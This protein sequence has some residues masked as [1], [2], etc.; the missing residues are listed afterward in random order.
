M[1]KTYKKFTVEQDLA[2]ACMIAEGKTVKEIASHIKVDNRVVEH[3][4]KIM[5]SREKAV[6]TTHLIARL[7][8]MAKI[9]PEL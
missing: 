4:I 5:K 7:M 2:I 8:R 9:C 1:S 6:S 3:R